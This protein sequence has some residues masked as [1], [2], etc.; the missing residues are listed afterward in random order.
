MRPD[1]IVVAT[2]VLN[3][4]PGLQAV[5]EP[6]HGK[7]FIAELPIETFAGVVLREIR[8]VFDYF[9]ASA[10]VILSPHATTLLVRA[11]TFSHVLLDA[12]DE[13]SHE[14]TPGIR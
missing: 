8:F 7:A 2:P 11:L 14:I 6:F 1:F 12:D 5:A 9:F 10:A 3:D 4:Y 13:V